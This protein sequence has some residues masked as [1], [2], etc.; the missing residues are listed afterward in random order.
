MADDPKGKLTDFITS[1]QTNPEEKTRIICKEQ[2]EWYLACQ[3]LGSKK[4]LD[5]DFFNELVELDMRDMMS[6]Q[7][8]RSEEVVISLSHLVGDDMANVGLQPLREYLKSQQRGG[9]GNK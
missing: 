6:Y 8:K 4:G 9:D 1:G 5:M 7:G 2:K 3:V